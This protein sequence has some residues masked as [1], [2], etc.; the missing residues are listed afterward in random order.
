VV[1]L[2]AAGVN[3]IIARTGKDLPI[4]K[5]VMIGL[6]F[7]HPIFYA[8]HHLL[9]PRTKEEIKPVIDF[10][11]RHRHRDD[12]LYVYYGAQNAFEYYKNRS[13]FADRNY[14][15]GVKSRD[16]LSRYFADVDKLRHSKR[17][18]LLFS[19]V[20]NGRGVDEEEALLLYVDTIGNRLNG[21]KRDGA[22]A[23]LYDL[24]TLGP[25]ESITHLSN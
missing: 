22:A 13:G 5:P 19:H 17:V 14:I 20:H 23:Y 21:Y 3:E 4:M 24:S 12:I 8:G 10:V 15:L 2:V 1:L 11:N 25:T 9:H 18:W 6:L 16:N 7:L